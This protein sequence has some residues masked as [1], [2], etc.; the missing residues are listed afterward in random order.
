MKKKTG[1]L[2]IPVMAAALLIFWLKPET[3]ELESADRPTAHAVLAGDAAPAAAPVAFVTGLEKLPRSLHD[4]EVDGELTVDENGRL[5]ITQGVR[6]VFDYFLSALGEEPLET[7]LQRLRAYIRHKLPAVAAIEAEGILDGYIAYKKGLAHL[8]EVAQ[9]GSGP[10]DTAA[11]RRQLQQVQ[12]LR[13]QFLSPPVIAAFFEGE[14]VYERYTLARFDILQNPKL[15]PQARAKQLAEVELQLPPALRESLKVANQVQNL[16]SLTED[17]Q[18][19]GGSPAELRQIRE[20]LVGPDATARLETL[21]RE[22]AAWAQRMNAW[23]SERAAILGNR[24]LGEQ[25]RAAQID[26]LRAQRFTAE[27]RPRVEAL[28]HL[29][30]NG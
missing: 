14:D 23:N 29:Q 27:E 18:K 1:L 21:D 28:E 30:D 11:L 6:N 5:R 3:V 15:T 19:R 4:T 26:A 17:W 22:R 16:A 24:S 7:I 20:Q 10:I 2:L 8:Q 25:D 13:T 9:P 12:A